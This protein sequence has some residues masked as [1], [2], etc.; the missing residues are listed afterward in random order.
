[1][2]CSGSI[3]YQSFRLSDVAA[4][5]PRYAHSMYLRQ[6]QACAHE[7]RRPSCG[8]SSYAFVAFE[9]LPASS[10]AFDDRA[11]WPSDVTDGDRDRF[12]A[13]IAKA[14]M[15]ALFSRGVRVTLVR[16]G[17][18]AVGSSEYAY[19][20]ATKDAMAALFTDPSCWEREAAR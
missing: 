2:K 3:R 15:D 5:V 11:E 12:R 13:A 6:P 1:M 17:H 18:D 9:C 8:P 19:Y 16:V 10:F 7:W 20:Q 14:V 4:L